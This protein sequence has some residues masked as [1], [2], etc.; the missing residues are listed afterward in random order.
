[1]E[2]VLT[3]IKKF[4]GIDEDYEQFD[5]D[6]IIHINSVLM[7]LSQLGIEPKKMVESKEDTWVQVIGDTSN[8]QTLSAVKSYIYLKVRLLF[9][10]PTSSVVTEAI[11]RQISELEWRLNASAEI[12]FDKTLQTISDRL[13]QVT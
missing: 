3:S 10:P 11:N 9:D 8:I 4:L 13:D 5:Q 7:V 12:Q 1:M 2:S 6:V